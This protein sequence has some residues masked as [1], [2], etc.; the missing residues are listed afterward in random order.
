MRIAWTINTKSEEYYMTDE[1][2]YTRWIYMIKSDIAV[3]KERILHVCDYHIS[4]WYTFFN[5]DSLRV[6]LILYLSINCKRWPVFEEDE[7]KPERGRVWPVLESASF[8]VGSNRSDNYAQTTTPFLRLSW[9][10]DIKLK[11]K[12]Y[13]EALMIAFTVSDW[14]CMCVFQPQK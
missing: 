9:G 8:G 11:W 3:I 6:L 7:N 14:V 12:K 4:S 10:H 2:K 1:Y 13:V 5:T